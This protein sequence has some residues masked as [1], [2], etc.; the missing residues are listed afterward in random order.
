M[1]KILLVLIS[2][3]LAFSASVSFSRAYA[4]KPSKEVSTVVFTANLHCDK[5]VKKVEE[6]ISFEKGVKDLE[7]S[8]KDKTIRIKYDPSRTDETKL[9]SAVS[10]LGYKVSKIEQKK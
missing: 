9:A 4:A 2:L 7:V 6:N 1:K 8:L 10:K 3:V 5:C